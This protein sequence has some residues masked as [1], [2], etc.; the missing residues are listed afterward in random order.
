MSVDPVDLEAGGLSGG[1][2]GYPCYRPEHVLTDVYP[3][4]VRG[5]PENKG[6][7]RNEG[8]KHATVLMEVA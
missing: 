8:S 6:A 3:E 4:Q 5:Q 7:A 2:Q 1:P